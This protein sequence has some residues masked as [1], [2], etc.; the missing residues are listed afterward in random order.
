MNFFIGFIVS[1][2]FGLFS[3]WRRSV[4]PSGLWGGVG[5]G[6]FLYGFAGPEGFCLLAFFFVVATVLTRLG[7][8]RKQAMGVAQ[9]NQGRRRAREALANCLPG[10][11]FAY[12]VWRQPGILLFQVALVSSLAESLAD[13]TSTELGQ[14]YGRRCVILPACR[15]VPVG[16]RGAVSVE[17]TLFGVLA[18]FAMGI[19]GWILGF[20]PVAGSVWVALGA[21]IGFTGESLIGTVLT[22]HEARNATG[23][24]LGGLTGMAF[25]E[26]FS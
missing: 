15:S 12:L 7:Q 21:T 6:T 10:L 4:S 25:F 17:G 22:N 5:I 1:L 9:P 2:A 19:L 24:F 3:Y 11:F 20:Y 18:A 26:W 14:L 8:K 16:T 13:T 23:S